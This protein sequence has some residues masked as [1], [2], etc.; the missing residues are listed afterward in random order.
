MMRSLPLRSRSA[1]RSQSW[2]NANVESSTRRYSTPTPCDDLPGKWQAAT[3]EAE[4]N[5][6]KLRVVASN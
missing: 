5:R 6:P 2:A 1:R 3:P 4:Q